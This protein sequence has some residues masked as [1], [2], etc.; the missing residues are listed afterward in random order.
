MWQQAAGIPA[1]LHLDCEHIL[2]HRGMLLE[3]SGRVCVYINSS[4]AGHETDR[5]TDSRLKLLT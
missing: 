5:H 4:E 1:A 2:I 3:V